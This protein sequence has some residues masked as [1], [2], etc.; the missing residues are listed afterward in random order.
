MGLVIFSKKPFQFCPNWLYQLWLPFTRYVDFKTFLRFMCYCAL[1][2]FGQV[3][4]LLI[5]TVRLPG[6]FYFH[7]HNWLPLHF[8]KWLINLQISPKFLGTVEYEESQISSFEILSH[9][10]LQAPYKWSKH[11]GLL[12]VTVH[13][14]INEDFYVVKL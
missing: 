6:Y 13:L 1:Y 2:Q 10:F 3:L 7:C 11:V 5:G 14:T 4:L 8:N 9:G 12:Q